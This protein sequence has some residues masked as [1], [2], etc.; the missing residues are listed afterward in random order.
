M[1]HDTRHETE[2]SRLNSTASPHKEWGITSQMCSQV[3]EKRQYADLKQPWLNKYWGCPVLWRVIV[4]LSNC[5]FSGS[6]IKP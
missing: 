1:A 2:N 6:L 5:L 4:N 3:P